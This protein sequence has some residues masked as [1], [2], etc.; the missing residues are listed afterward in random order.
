M[1]LSSKDHIQRLRENGTFYKLMM[2]S[3]FN[4]KRDDEKKGYGNC[5]DCDWYNNPDK[6]NVKRD[7]PPCLLNRRP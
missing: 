3:L 1:K 6:C 2:D 5:A 7:S 4:M